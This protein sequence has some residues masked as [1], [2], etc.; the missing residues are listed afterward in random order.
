M[1]SGVKLALGAAGALAALSI[2]SAHRSGSA[3]SSVVDVE[4]MVPEL[5]R[6]WYN[7][8]YPYDP[9]VQ[10][11]DDVDSFRLADVGSMPAEVRQW[12]ERATGTRVLGSGN[13]RVVVAL[14][15][16]TVVKLALDSWGEKENERELEAWQEY[17]GT[18][19]SDFLAPILSGW[20]HAVV[21]KQA[22]ALSGEALTANARLRQAFEQ[23]RAAVE[24][25][26]RAGEHFI[27]D[28]YKPSNWGVLD[29]KIV[30]ID[31]AEAG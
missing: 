7:A 15:D 9:P 25:L 22:K 8:L 27:E 6:R 26:Y 17:E 11:P 21:M 14:G 28:T 12:W 16:G 13:F 4:G 19:V 5:V 2:F 31:Y 3:S 23:R 1:S 29:G 30:L 20:Q 10:D 18:P 24:T